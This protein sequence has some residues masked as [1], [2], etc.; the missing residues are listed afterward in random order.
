MDFIDVWQNKFDS[1]NKSFKTE[2]DK[3]KNQNPENI[4]NVSQ[5]FDNSFQRLS[6]I[7][8]RAKELYDYYEENHQKSKNELKNEIDR[9][10]DL[11]R[12]YEQIS[13]EMNDILN[14]IKEDYFI[15]KVFNDPC[16][17]LYYLYRIDLDSYET[18]IFIQIRGFISILEQLVK[19]RKREEE[20]KKQTEIRRLETQK[21]KEK[22]LNRKDK[23]VVQLVKERK[24]E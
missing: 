24:R 15:E 8:P 21:K 3:I 12:N 20:R 9:I 11:V 17:I 22:G 1:I 2:M 6:S 18:N 5:L 13:Q 10:T 19:E 7:I 16:N 4:K 14:N 23:V